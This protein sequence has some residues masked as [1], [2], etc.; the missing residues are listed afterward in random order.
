MSWCVHRTSTACNRQRHLRATLCCLLQCAWCW[1][2]DLYMLTYTPCLLHCLQKAKFTQIFT[3][4]KLGLNNF[5]SF[6]PYQVCPIGPS[7]VLVLQLKTGPRA[8]SIF[9]NMPFCSWV[10][11]DLYKEYTSSL[12]FLFFTY[13]SATSI[14]G[15]RSGRSNKTYK[16]LTGEGRYCA[17]Q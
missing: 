7:E 4:E 15:W 17:R 2:E 3:T 5:E 13:T 12:H 1:L 6:R 8:T 9:N 10:V 16:S 11:S 14:T